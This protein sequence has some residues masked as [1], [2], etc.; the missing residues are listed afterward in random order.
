MSYVRRNFDDEPEPPKAAPRVDATPSSPFAVIGNVGSPYTLKLRGYLRYRRIPNVFITMNPQLRQKYVTK[1][2]VIPK[3]LYPDGETLL[4]DSTPMIQRLE[5]ET[6]HLGRTV[7]LPEPAIQ[8]LAHLIEDFADEWVTKIMFAARWFHPRDQLFGR[9][10]V[11][12]G[13]AFPER[14]EIADRFATEIM[15]RQ[16]GR[17]P[18]VFGPTSNIHIINQTFDAVMSIL[19]EHL[20]KGHHFVLGTRTR[21]TIADFALYGQLY[22]ICVMDT[23][24]SLKAREEYA[25]RAFLYC[26]RLDDLSGLGFGSSATPEEPKITSLPPTTL[27]LIRLVGQLY[28]PFLLANEKACR[29]EGADKVPF[30]V[31]FGDDWASYTGNAF[32]YQHKCL[33]W[34][35]EHLAHALRTASY[36]NRTAL[37]SILKDAGCWDALV[38]GEEGIM[39]GEKVKL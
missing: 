28:I 19:E 29:T 22:Q 20:A 11:G 16:V 35:R 23:T 9:K 36:E 24:Y 17:N 39:E 34:L 10:L 33:L 5:R 8:F 38:Y 31:T 21:P 18:L 3:L 1:A 32:R 37:E 13:N 25:G 7:N 14:A 6:G 4:A 30:K 2:P 26:L 12:I 27:Q 15:N